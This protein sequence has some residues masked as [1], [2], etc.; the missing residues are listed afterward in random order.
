MT[1]KPSSRPKTTTF[2]VRVQFRDNT[3]WQG[4]IEW[5]EGKKSKPFRSVLELIMLM[6]E[7][8]EEAN[9]DSVD[10]QFHTWDDQEGVS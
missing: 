4:R 9:P 10:I 1:E 3:S 8:Q 7:A 5:L 2:L 6:Q